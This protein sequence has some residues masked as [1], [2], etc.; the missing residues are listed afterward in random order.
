[1]KIRLLKTVITG[2]CFLLS[3]ISC[4]LFTDSNP[5]S[6]ANGT[7]RVKFEN[8]SGSEFTI[9]SIQLMAMGEAGATTPSPS[10]TWGENVLADGTT[11]APGEHTFFTVDIPNLHWSKYR[12]GVLDENDAQVYV[13]EPQDTTV[14]WFTGSITHWGSDER[15]VSATVMRDSD[16]D[17]IVQ[18]GY[19]D[20]A[21]ID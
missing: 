5:S 16:C 12:L 21:G 6:G 20:F 7:L 2:C 11:L 10:G 3:I 9:F 19:S 1:M 17:C 13:D 4:D 14:M 15:T 18:S 8:E